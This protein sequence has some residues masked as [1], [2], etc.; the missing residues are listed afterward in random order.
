MNI[1]LDEHSL[2]AAQ[3]QGR[4]CLDDSL[5][6]VV[7][8]SRLADDEFPEFLERL[9]SGRGEFAL[10][11]SGGGELRAAVDRLRSIPLFYGTTR[12]ACFV[13]TNPYWVRS[14]IGGDRVDPQG[15][16]ELWYMLYVLRD[17]TLAAGVKQLRPGEALRVVMHP[18]GP[19]V[20]THAYYRYINQPCVS[21]DESEL[22][23]ELDRLHLLVF[24]ELLSSLRDR[25][26]IVPLSGGLDS[27]LLVCMLR[28][29]GARDVVCFTYGS[30][31]NLE[32][33]TSRRVAERLGYRWL[34][35]PYGGRDWNSCFFRQA[36]RQFI[37]FASRLCA[38]PPLLE[39]WL[40][41]GLMKR[42][43]DIPADAVFCPGHTA[44]F[45]SGR[46]ALNAAG[47]TEGLSSLAESILR[48]NSPRLRWDRRPESAISDIQPRIHRSLQ[49]MASDADSKAFDL[50]TL[51]EAWN[52]SERQSKRII[53]MTSAYEFWGYQW[54]VPLW[55][56]RLMDFWGRV[57]SRLRLS[58]AL[59]RRYLAESSETRF[60]G[61]FNGLRAKA[62]GNLLP[63]A[64]WADVLCRRAQ[65]LSLGRYFLAEKCMERLLVRNCLAFL[66]VIGRR[67]LS[68]E[69]VT[70]P[71]LLLEQYGIESIWQ[72]DCQAELAHMS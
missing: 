67:V 22:M 50:G 15:A 62:A 7:S 36:R 12:S 40:A 53:N 28:R 65:H 3:L 55:D 2:P 35:V 19:R 33:R 66:S 6:D 11:I 8:S 27:R 9:R 1:T 24:E 64:G 43:G 70:S 5:V 29:L 30:G 72:G 45:S 4:L 68:S 39:D 23:Q 57:P 17:G 37:P 44:V 13:S 51:L 32:A 38:L 20:T 10:V 58:K 61:L 25:A 49:E 18:D 14:K 26:I 47:E 34:L 59:Y 52:W 41:V 16:R 69:P 60:Y 71:W 31:R 54:R 48:S 42:R 63:R 46:R 21:E 56:A